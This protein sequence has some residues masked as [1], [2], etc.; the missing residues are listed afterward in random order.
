MWNSRGLGNL[1]IGKE[2]GE[3]VRAKDPSI[4][5]IA[6][7][8]TDK[9]RLD[10]IQHYINFKH[11]RVVKS[12]NRGGGLVLFWKSSVNLTVKDTFKYYIDAFIN[13]DTDE[14]W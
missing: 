13:K 3:L 12:S 6:E 7:T 8:W 10:W 2:I 1:R 5:F 14:E 4:I 11:K 9:A